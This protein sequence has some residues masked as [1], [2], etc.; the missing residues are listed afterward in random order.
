MVMDKIVSGIW[1]VDF[2]EV[3][4]K[5]IDKESIKEIFWNQKYSDS[6]CIEKIAEL[7][8]IHRK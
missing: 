8:G 3:F 1:S 2:E 5:Y 7:V 4:D 6:E